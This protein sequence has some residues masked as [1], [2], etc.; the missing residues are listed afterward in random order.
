[1]Q[2]GRELQTVDGKAVFQPFA[3]ARGTFGVPER[4]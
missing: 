4:R 2:C 1:M 3:L